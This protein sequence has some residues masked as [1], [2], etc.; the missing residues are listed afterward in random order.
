MGKQ[1]EREL[2]A[3]CGLYCGD[4]I[5]YRSRAADLA[6]DLLSELQDTEFDKYAEAKRLSRDKAEELEHYQECCEVLTAMVRLQCNESCRVASGCPTFSCKIVECCQKKGFE[7][8]WQCGEF[9][10]CREFESLRPFHGDVPIMNL[11][12]IGELG[13]DNWVEYRQK[14]YIW[15]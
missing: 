3:Y 7:G 5:R 11:E 4:C 6:R 12:K 8:C 14:F 9:E 13:L 2:T 15:Q 10:N 1:R